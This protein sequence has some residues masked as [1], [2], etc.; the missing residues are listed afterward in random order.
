MALSGGPLPYTRLLRTLRTYEVA[1]GRERPQPVIQDAVLHRTL[2]WMQ[3]RGLV[4]CAR[5]QEFPFPAV[6]WLTPAA[7]E[8]AEL[9]MPMAEWAAQHEDLLELDRRARSE[10]RRKRVRTGRSGRKSG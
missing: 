9:V 5:G 6:Y 8:L 7:H 4:E 10:R 1:R 2:R 3:Q